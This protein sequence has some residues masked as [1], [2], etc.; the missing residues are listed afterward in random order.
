MH[1]PLCGSRNVV[2]PC[3]LGHGMSTQWPVESGP[4]P[5]AQMHTPIMIWPSMQGGGGGS[6]DAVDGGPAGAGA[7]A[8]PGGPA[9]CDGSTDAGASGATDPGAD[10]ESDEGTG[11]PGGTG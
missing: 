4:L 3:A 2:P 11:A 10:D 1:P 8:E 6:P 7:S 9:A 5:F